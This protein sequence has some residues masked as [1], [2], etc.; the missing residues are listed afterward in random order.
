MQGV[1]G[2][3]RNI[4]HD[5]KKNL[6]TALLALLIVLPC[7]A[8]PASAQET[9][10]TY[11]S[12]S[13]EELAHLSGLESAY[14]LGVRAEA[15]KMVGSYF[16]THTIIQ[17]F[18]PQVRI[19]RQRKRDELNAVLRYLSSLRLEQ[20]FISLYIDILREDAVDQ[21][22]DAMLAKSRSYRR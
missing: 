16:D 13:A 1:K 8:W 10:R 5:H 4:M 6:L 22:L 20:E 19:I 2:S 9:P 18:T 17:T 12:L 14:F 11:D 7:F 3:M 15:V 21:A